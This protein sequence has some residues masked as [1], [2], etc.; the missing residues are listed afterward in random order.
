MQ[1]SLYTT[2][3]AKKI[4]K[5]FNVSPAKL[6]HLVTSQFGELGRW[7][8]RGADIA[9]SEV[10]YTPK[11]ATRP[12]QITDYP[13]IGAFVARDPTGFGS[14]TVS[15]FFDAYEKLQR[16]KKTGPAMAKVATKEDVVDYLRNRKLETAAIATG[17]YSEIYGGVRKL[18]ELRK[19]EEA[20]IKSF[21]PK[22]KKQAAIDYLDAEVMKIVVPTMD[23]WRYLED[24]VDKAEKE[25]VKR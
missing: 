15:R 12:A 22:E 20:V 19:Q 3:L 23:R 6:E 24:A 25:K 5:R 14:E 8:L 21:M 9:S 16:V 4:G 17:L 10:G 2:E 18:S 13:V 1:Y 7:G 11:T